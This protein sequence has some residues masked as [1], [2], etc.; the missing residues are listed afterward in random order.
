MVET[1]EI[2]TIGV[3]LA[4]NV[5]QICGMDVG[6]NVVLRRRVKFGQARRPAAR[7]TP[8]ALRSDQVVLNLTHARNTE[9][10]RV[11]PPSVRMSGQTALGSC[12]ATS[13]SGQ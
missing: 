1:S 7:S 11:F 13:P 12:P 4:K 3:D 10:M 6:G 2:A 5:F 8:N 9:K